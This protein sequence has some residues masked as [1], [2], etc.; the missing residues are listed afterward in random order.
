M[1]KHG[2]MQIVKY[3]T[4]RRKSINVIWLAEELDET[5]ARPNRSSADIHYISWR[6]TPSI[7]VN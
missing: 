3:N 2:G 7:Y 6:I 4:D 5:A 1:L